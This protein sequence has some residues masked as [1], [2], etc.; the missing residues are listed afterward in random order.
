[1]RIIDKIK[2]ASILGGVI[3]A[4]VFT[5]CQKDIL[6]EQDG[7]AMEMEL[8]ASIETSVKTKAGLG[9]T[10]SEN[11]TPV[12]WSENE[13]IKVYSSSASAVFS[14]GSGAGT[15]TAKFKGKLTGN[16]EKAIFPVCLSTERPDY[17]L[18]P[19]KQV[20]VK[21]GVSQA[22]FPMAAIVDG[23]DMQF[24]N[25]CGIL[26][27]QLSSAEPVTVRS[28]TL[29]TGDKVAN[30]DYLSGMA[31]V[32][33]GDEPSLTFDSR[34]QRYVRLDCSSEANG[35]VALSS[36]PVSF[37]IVV[38]P[39]TADFFSIEVETTDNRIVYKRT[40]ANEQNIIARS[41]IKV[42]PAITLEGFED[43]Y[44]K[45]TF[46][47]NEGNMSNE[48]GT[49]TYISQYGSVTDS[50][51]YKAN[52]YFL[53]NVSQDMFFGD[54]KIYVVAQNGTAN[55]GKGTL[56]IA[57][58][59]T[60]K[61]EKIYEASA[62]PGISWPSH[63]AVAEG[64]AYIRDNKGISAFNLSSEEYTFVEGSKGAS[65]N[66]MAVIGTKVFVP[67]GQKIFV[68][69]KS[70]IVHTITELP[71][72]VSGIIRTDDDNLY[73]SCTSSPAQILKISSSDY[74][75]IK[76]NEITESGIS[77]GWGASPAIS[78]KGDNIYFNNAKTTIYRHNFTSGETVM[79]T[80]VA[81]HVE[82][83]GV[84]YNNLGV[85]PETEEVFFTTMKGYGMDYKVNDISVFDFTS[86]EVI[87]KYD[88]QEHNSFP[89]G[90]FFPQNY[91]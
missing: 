87:F 82:F 83:P 50:A 24:K 22:A 91:R 76:S 67:A 69:E 56:V 31:T 41:E 13:Q 71:G 70:Q 16:P 36:D 73:V 62:F 68:I 51:Y 14:L 84:V 5:S 1:M 58:A 60:L 17:I 3:M 2:Y 54:G 53:G 37:H 40:Q 74:S 85:N 77:A 63:V 81:S 6:T 9:E 34:S 23:S 20:Y 59:K 89:A 11:K 45:G 88:F 46:V 32:N 64:V 26:K 18:L 33:F 12:I 35:G 90:I 25:L 86:G 55:G 42:M 7:D 28:I 48:T 10:T 57:D 49:L 61:N 4:G 75:V 66:R 30:S 27:L 65:K 43:K 79:M 29:W 52:G 21:D 39:T 15:N 47:L 78:A 72:S 38:P 80:D 19:S 8:S 44:S